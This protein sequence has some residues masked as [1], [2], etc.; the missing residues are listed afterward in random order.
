V[1]LARAIGRGAIQALIILIGGVAAIVIGAEITQR[2]RLALSLPESQAIGVA[3]IVVL[4]AAA[5]GIWGALMWRTER[6]G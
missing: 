4:V 5:G 6:H 3:A 2:I 1:S